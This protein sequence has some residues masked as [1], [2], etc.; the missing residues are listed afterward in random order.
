LAGPIGLT[1]AAMSLE[2]LTHSIKGAADIPVIGLDVRVDH[3]G[4]NVS[5]TQQTL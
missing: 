2:V 5:V 3:G 4:F 1:N